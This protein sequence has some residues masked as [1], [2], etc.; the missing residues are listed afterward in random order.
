MGRGAVF[1]G[2]EYIVKSNPCYLR[3]ALSGRGP[4]Y[5]WVHSLRRGSI[6]PCRRVAG[7]G[8]EEAGDGGRG[9]GEGREEVE[10]RGEGGGEGSAHDKKQEFDGGVRLGTGAVFS[11]KE[12]IVKRVPCYLRGTL[13]GRG[14]TCFGGTGE[15]GSGHDNKQ[16]PE[17]GPCLF[18]RRGA[19]GLFMDFV[20]R[21][22]SQ[23]AG[24]RIRSF[25]MDGR[26]CMDPLP[27]ELAQLGGATFWGWTGG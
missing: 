9:A 27:D 18:C 17:G 12:Y 13:S 6:T 5:F 26:L 14:S 22:G 2:K 8:R 7:E 15:R 1:S 11:G 23:R 25:G 4:A 20:G 16:G 21:S 19:V 10:S 3:A 24:H